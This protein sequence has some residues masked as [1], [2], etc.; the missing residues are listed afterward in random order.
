MKIPDWKDFIIKAKEV[1]TKTKYYTTR[2]RLQAF[3]WSNNVFLYA[4]LEAF[5]KHHLQLL[6]DL[7]FTL[8]EPTDEEKLE[9]GLT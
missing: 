2:D 3:F 8:A 6:R 4:E 5:D 7:G 9:W 1:R